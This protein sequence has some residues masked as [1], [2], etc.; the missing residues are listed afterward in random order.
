M[1]EKKKNKNKIPFEWPKFA[2]HI[3]GMLVLA[4]SSSSGSAARLEG[5]HTVVSPQ[6]L[7]M[8]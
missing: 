8:W 7:T 2:D 5:I 4:I 6:H 1:K 3:R